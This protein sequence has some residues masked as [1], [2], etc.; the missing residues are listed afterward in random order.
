[1]TPRAPM[2]VTAAV[3]PVQEARDLPASPKHSATH[4]ILTASAITSR[5]LRPSWPAR[6]TASRAAPDLGVELA[7]GQQLEGTS[8]GSGLNVG[9]P[10]PVPVPT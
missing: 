6:I 5:H 3:G 1:M 8:G 7:D 4:V 9:S 10:Q 2:P